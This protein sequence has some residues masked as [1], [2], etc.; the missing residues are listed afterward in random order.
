MGK[1]KHSIGAKNPRSRKQAKRRPSVTVDLTKPEGDD[2]PN[3][4]SEEVEGTEE[5]EEEN[6]REPPQ[7]PLDPEHSLDG[8]R[9]V[10]LPQT[11]HWDPD[12][13]DGQKIGWKVR[14]EYGVSKWANGRIVRYDPHSHKH[15]L[16]LTDENDK[17]ECGV[18]IW[19]RNDQHNIHISTRLVW[20]HVKGYAWWPALVTE[21]NA[22]DD[23]K[24]GYVQVEFFASGDAST[25][26]DSPECIRPFSPYTLDPV[27][28]KHRKKRNAKAFQL[29]CEEFHRIRKARNEAALFYAERAFRFAQ[30]KGAGLVGKRI[31]VYRNDVNYPAG[32][33]VRGKVRKYSVVQ[34]KWLVS[35]EISK[36]THKKYE[37]A[38]INLKGRGSHLKVLDEKKVIVDNEALIPFLVGYIGHE[39]RDDQDENE[40][41]IM[42]LLHDRCRG[43]VECFRKEEVPIRCEKCNAP[44]HLGCLDP[45]LLLEQYQRYLKD[46]SVF[47]CPTCKQCRGCYQRDV[48][49]GSHPL[50][51]IPT[52]LSFPP[53]ESLDVCSTCRECYSQTQYCPNCAHT[54]DDS[55]YYEVRKQL[56]WSGNSEGRKRKTATAGLDSL[57]EDSNFPVKF[58]SYTGDNSLPTGA[59]VH[60]SCYH[61]ETTQWGYTE[62]EMLVCDGC[63]VWVHAGCAGISEEE[64]DA[65]SERSHP[66][67]SKE[68]L[69][70]QCCRAR[71]KKLIE[72][73]QQEDTSLLFAE[74]VNERVAP[75]Y[76]DVIKTPIDLKTM[77]KKAEG[78]DY[79][80]YAW[81]R[82]DFELMVYN[83][84]T[85]NRFVSISWQFC[86]AP[87]F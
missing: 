9:A 79:L 20:A 86:E 29:A 37:P 22:E 6:Q 30:N 10:I 17:R 11:V 19:I 65:T 8:T 1:R 59:R 83:A 32:D 4:S 40:R 42:N 33:L 34:K 66:I 74:P 26:R 82:D 24:N 77:M 67:Y 75:N 49:F 50:E 16:T 23:R 73:M 27:V 81:V 85:F 76:R 45:P 56:E 54:W 18:W 47:I 12:S 71:C 55:R 15:K 31:Q 61:V 58:G 52:N 72:A 78:D 5:E 36:Q 2:L 64:Y 39:K 53:G 70:R 3:T 21:S 69:C 44:Y 13:P 51:K 60:P 25:L 87:R 80:N 41:L 14:I 46:G 7:F 38:W 35:F 43:C 68:F 62:V 28:V 57:I 63:H 48:A 84:L